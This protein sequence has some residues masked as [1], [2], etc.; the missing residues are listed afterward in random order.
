MKI[1]LREGNIRNLGDN[2]DTFSKDKNQEL[3]S[4]EL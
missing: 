2:F 3:N 4:Y 1:Y